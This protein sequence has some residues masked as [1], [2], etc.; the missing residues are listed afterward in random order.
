MEFLT[1]REVA[2]LLRVKERKI[3][4]LAAAGKIPCRR[5]TRKLLFPKD[6]IMAW[7]EGDGLA[8]VGEAASARSRGPVPMVMAGSHDPLLDWAL[9][10]SGSGM[11]AFFDGSGDGL[12][13]FSR[14]EACAVGL[15][16]FDP[17]AGDWNRHQVRTHCDGQ[18]AVLIAWAHREMG[19]LVREGNPLNLQSIADLQTVRVARR[20]EGAGA[21]VLFDHLCT[22]AGLDPQTLKANAPL[23]RTELEAAFMVLEGKAE[24]AL[25]LEA[26]ARQLRLSFVALK[27]ERYD[28]LIDR[29]AYFE[30][31]FQTLLQFARTCE[32]F[33]HAE[34]MGGYDLAVSGNVLWN[35]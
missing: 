13:R 20:Q 21:G 9:R 4:D 5:L 26:M 28:L 7:L 29:R 33:Q 17:E 32:F 11:G 24:A 22:E 34:E 31:A 16:L 35:G 1:T 14:G 30:P 27:R 23:A 12:A 18:P 2:A 10:E 15:H 6:E 19:L 3:Y 25:G 8:A